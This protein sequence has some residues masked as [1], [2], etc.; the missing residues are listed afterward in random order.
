MS[1]LSFWKF[2]KP[3][4]PKSLPLT[5]RVVLSDSERERFE[6]T[7]D[8]S[9]MWSYLEQHPH[10]FNPGVPAMLLTTLT[11]YTGK[12]RDELLLSDMVIMYKSIHRVLPDIHKRDREGRVNFVDENSLRKWNV[13]NGVTFF[14]ISQYTLL[15]LYIDRQTSAARNP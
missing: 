15:E 1:Q 12:E 8:K 3:E 4:L 14:G 6:Q 5:D 7:L 10:Y 11:Q 2:E 9:L 13:A